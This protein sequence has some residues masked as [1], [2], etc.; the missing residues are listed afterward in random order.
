MLFESGGKREERKPHV[1]S[2]PPNQSVDSI[3]PVCPG[4]RIDFHFESGVGTL[5]VTLSPEGRMLGGLSG[6]LWT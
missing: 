5:S 4:R 2:R 1:R 6:S 3:P